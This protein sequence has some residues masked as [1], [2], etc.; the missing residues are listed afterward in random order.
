ML[1]AQVF[2]RA[3]TSQP[4]RKYTHPEFEDGYRRV[5]LSMEFRLRNKFM[6]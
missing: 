2:V 5:E 6:D 3:R 1:S 4:D